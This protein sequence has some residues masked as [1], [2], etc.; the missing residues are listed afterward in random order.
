M[1]DKKEQKR[2]TAVFSN[3]LKDLMNE[4]LEDQLMTLD[5]DI[6]H[7]IYGR[8]SVMI[9]LNDGKP[10]GTIAD[11]SA[12][13]GAAFGSV[14]TE[15]VNGRVGNAEELT[16]IVITARDNLVEGFQARAPSL[17]APEVTV[18]EEAAAE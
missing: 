11:L 9:K 2:D 17:L 5:R 13:V 4:P 16:K 7:F 6:Q 1:I 10:I 15:F 3:M 12:V 18:P 14:L 8:V